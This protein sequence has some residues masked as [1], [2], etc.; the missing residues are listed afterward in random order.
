M[1][2]QGVE[3]GEREWAWDLY[4]KECPSYRRECFCTGDNA[5]IPYLVGGQVGLQK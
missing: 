5:T 2:A 3:E 1:G 4:R